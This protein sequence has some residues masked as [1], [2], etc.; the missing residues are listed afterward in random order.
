MKLPIFWLNDYIQVPEDLE[1]LTDK[2]TAIGHMQ[3]HKLEKVDGETV[4][5]LE[6][7]QNR[8][9]CLSIIGLARELSAVLDIK[10]SLPKS[11]GDNLPKIDN[12]IKINDYS[13]GLCLRFN[14]LSF[15]GVKIQKSPE[16]LAKKLEVYGIK[17]I[18]NLVDISNYVMVETGQPLHLFDSQDTKE[19]IIRKALSNE[20][21]AVLGKKSV[22]LSDDDL[23]IANENEI[24][25]IAGVIGAFSKAI[26]EKHINITLESATYNQASIRRTALRHDLRTEASLRNEKFLNPQMTEIALKRASELILDLCGG[27]IVGHS[28][29]YPKPTVSHSI[30]L[31]INEIIR[32]GGIK[33]EKEMIEEIF[34]KLGITITKSDENKIVTRIP[35]F[36]TD[37]EEEADLVEEILRIY[38]YNNIPERL[39]ESATPKDVQSEIYTLEEKIR[40][41]MIGFGFDEEITEPLTKE[42]KPQLEPIILE[43][44]LNSQK[45]MLRTTLKDNLFDVLKNRRR[46]RKKYSSIFEIGKIYFKNGNDYIE[47]RTLG[48][49]VSTENAIYLKV[50]GL[51]EVLLEQLGY[52]YSDDYIKIN[53][54]GD[55]VSTLYFEINLEKVI[56]TNRDLKLRVL[57]SPQQIV[58]EDISFEVSK[59]IRVGEVIEK[60]KDV[61]PYIYKVELGEN[62]RYLENTK[63]ILFKL[64]FHS[65][66]KKLNTKDTDPIKDKIVMML[67][68]SYS[69]KIR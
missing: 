17:S 12:N 46:Y 62:P 34:S 67:Q 35:Y 58:F 50:K 22:N 57:T 39:L 41:L 19:I 66:E 32:L 36:R 64:S 56:M 48:G 44:S 15:E 8:S 4:L 25:A 52:K 16:W 26:G 10:L 29:Y 21:V 28:D 18:N 1:L 40:D 31:D 49:I 23:V 27:K 33:I 2:L 45:T 51:I 30:N 53:N 7:R 68:E 47:E 24:L 55:S 65:T 5:D 43:N 69:A 14:T 20:T 13:N 42:E 54:I 59:N 9:D 61:S 38:G 6:I 60:I 37:L 3:D 63:T 11:F